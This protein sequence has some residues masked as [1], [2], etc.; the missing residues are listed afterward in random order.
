V[1][2]HRSLGEPVEQTVLY[3]G[4]GPLT[5]PASFRS[6][7]IRHEYTILN[8]REMD[9]AALLASDDWTDNEWALLTRSHPEE[10]IRVVFAK[11]RGLRGEEQREAA[12]SFM[13]LGGILGIETEIGRRFHEEMIDIMD[14]Q[15]LGPAIRQGLEQGLQQGMQQGVQQG[16]Q[17]GISYALHTVLESRF[18]AL[19]SWVQEKI[20]TASPE[21]RNRWLQTFHQ[22]TSLEEALR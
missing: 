13:I 7:G 20:T 16:M 17:Q 2:I 14:N 12:T 9:G 19:P 10:V 1:A 18:G 4:R 11:L 15:V 22:A 3:V 21:T 6:G 8:L 5:M